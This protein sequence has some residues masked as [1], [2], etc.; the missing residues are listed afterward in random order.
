MQKGE[1]SCVKEEIAKG[2]EW[3]VMNKIKYEWFY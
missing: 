2:N 3:R 1:G